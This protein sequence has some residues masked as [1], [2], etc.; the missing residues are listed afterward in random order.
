M[1]LS[2]NLIP[3]VPLLFVASIPTYFLN[4]YHIIGCEVTMARKDQKK[5]NKEMMEEHLSLAVIELSATKKVN[6]IHRRPYKILLINLL[7]QKKKLLL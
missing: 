5:H 4:F 6:M 2:Q 3:C 1:L 7:L